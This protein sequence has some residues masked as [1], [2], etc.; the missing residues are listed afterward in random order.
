MFEVNTE[1]KFTINIPVPSENVV[2][3]IHNDVYKFYW[4]CAI[5]PDGHHLVVTLSNSIGNKHSSF[6]HRTAPTK[7]MKVFARDG[8]QVY[9][10]PAE[11][12]TRYSHQVRLWM[13][14]VT[15][16]GQL[17]FDIVF[18]NCQDP[19][20]IANSA[21][22]FVPGS[23]P[24]LANL[25]K[26]IASM[27]LAFTFE[28]NVHSPRVSLWAHRLIL[29]QVPEIAKLIDYEKPNEG[30]L[31]SAFINTLNIS[32]YSLE[33]FCCLLRFLYTREAKLEVDL[34]DY[35]I[36]AFPSK[37]TSCI[38][39][40]RPAAEELLPSTATIASH[41]NFDDG[42]TGSPS[43]VV[44]A[45]SYNE[46]FQLAAMYDIVELRNHCR[47]KIV[48]SLDS[49]DASNMLE[50][51]FEFG[52]RYKDLKDVVLH[53]VA[54]NLEKMYAG[55]GVDP[56]HKYSDHP[57]KQALLAEVLMLKFKTSA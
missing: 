17:D 43:A 5:Q 15:V 20:S 36:G 40:V 12:L 52:Y 49:L 22:H 51:L 39:K 9:K 32:E 24:T 19:V 25:M 8:R 50:I 46:L 11:D 3:Y 6:M 29:A 53:H 56:L 14:A 54:D 57:E 28:G 31:N 33:S 2:N 48:E 45:A 13:D 7:T 44:R 34:D 38:C 47:V 55:G 21:E 26:D 1:T 16:D 4:K 27:D 18:S 37:S 35:A 42:G 41:A 30:I 23:H 10:K